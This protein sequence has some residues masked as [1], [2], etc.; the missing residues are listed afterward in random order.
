MH[1]M[2]FF[3]RPAVALPFK[4]PGNVMS[5]FHVIT[6]ALLAFAPVSATPAAA[7][8]V[9]VT[10]AGTFNG[11]LAGN[12]FTDETLSF[13]G[14]TNTDS[15]DDVFGEFHYV[16]SALSVRFDGLSYD[17]SEP[18]I[19]FIAPK[20]RMAGF[21][22]PDV[23]KGLIRF[24]YLNGNRVIDDGLSQPFETSGGKLQI[25]AGSNVSISGLAFPPPAAVPEPGTWLML[26]LGFAVTGA[27]VRQRRSAVALNRPGS[28]GDLG[29]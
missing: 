27:V 17:I 1:L 13:S 11:M 4:E 12:G 14:V 23:S 16:L 18:T 10:L 9:N 25:G 24:D 6:A 21:A 7:A 15:V 29:L 8:I 3:H 28:A 5:I 20:S 19:F 2:R 26:L 22:D